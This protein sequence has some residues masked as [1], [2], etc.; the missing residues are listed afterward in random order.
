MAAGMIFSTT[1]PETMIH[2]IEPVAGQTLQ[3][4]I[5][6]L[7]RTALFKDRVVLQSETRTTSKTN[8]SNHNALL[9][10]DRVRATLTPN[11][12][13]A[14]LKWDTQTK[15]LSAADFIA[16]K[17]GAG[18][19]SDRT[20]WTEGPFTR[21]KFSVMADDAYGIYMTEYVI[22]SALSMSVEMEFKD[23]I[24]ATE[25][26]QR[27]Y[28]Y[29]TNGTMLH[30]ID[31]S[32]DYPIPDD[33]Q[34]ILRHLYTLRGAQDEDGKDKTCFDWCKKYS[35][36]AITILTNR[37]D[38][39][40]AE[41]VVNK[42]HFQALFEIECS[43]EIPE[44]LEP[45]YAK[46]TFTVNLQF[47]RTN[48]LILEYPCIVNN[49]YVNFKYIPMSTTYRQGGTS[50]I[51]WQ[52]KAVAETWLQTYKRSKVWRPIHYPWWDPWIMPT[53]SF[54]YQSNYRPIYVCA[55][56]LDNPEDPE[57]ETV[58]DL[59]DGLP[60]TRLDDVI[61]KNIA[62]YKNA[63]LHNKQHV[64]V[65][66]FADDFQVE[67]RG[68]HTKKPLVDLSDGRH[69]ILR[70]RRKRSIFRV[71]ISLRLTDFVNNPRSHYSDLTNT[72]K[73]VDYNNNK[74][75]MDSDQTTIPTTFK[76]E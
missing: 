59:V 32:Y 7:G 12:N 4:I 10:P 66:V 71:V 70:S 48:M 75:D 29:F 47:A 76:K 38:G 55:I 2:I 23:H 25:T 20:P 73:I 53:D 41:A 33:I 9:R 67:Y 56:T 26:L 35:N 16:T 5:D 1:V 68:L 11:V 64:N 44:H 15:A 61:L 39:R 63:C 72:E 45:D 34:L 24:T 18:S 14:S 13:P 6:K 22:G 50:P 49:Q 8:D 60:G 27:L 21:R 54:V 65:S 37:N 28:Q 36:D 19:Q 52:N 74:V 51:L 57:G 3:Y 40:K 58:I 42:N 46:I 17:L 30:Y 69:L 31:L 62:T 43:Q